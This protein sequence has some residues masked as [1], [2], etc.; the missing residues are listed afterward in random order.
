MAVTLRRRLAAGATVPVFAAP[1]L[2]SGFAHLEL[3]ADPRVRLVSSPRHATVLVAVGRFPEG[4]DLAVDRVH[5]QLPH[6]RGVVRCSA[7][8]LDGPGCGAVVDEIVRIHCALL[9]GTLESSP[10]VLDDDPPNAFEG[11]GDH[12]QGGEGMMGGVPWGRPM[13]MTGDDRDGLALDRSAARMGPFLVGLPAGLSVDVVLQGGVVE[14][15]ELVLAGPV[16]SE[17]GTSADSHRARCRHLL[18]WVG[19]SCRLGGLEALSIHA[20]ATA[21]RIAT[22]DHRAGEVSHLTERV[23]RSGLGRS[24]KAVGRVDGLDEDARDR[25]NRRLDEVVD[26]ADQIGGTGHAGTSADRPWMPINVGSPLVTAIERSLTGMDWSS[27]LV[28]LC[29]LDLRLVEAGELAQDAP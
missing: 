4:L 16:G 19:E 9:G 1:G 20:A 6:P 27:A 18:R 15:A 29:S 10:D 24:W 13:A 21:R 5:D 11:L 26:A 28:T 17:A 7:E 25:L 12:G 2:G 14:Q 3:A 23:R 8:D 22:G